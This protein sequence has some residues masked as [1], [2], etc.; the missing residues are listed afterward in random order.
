MM[1][2]SPSSSYIQRE[3]FEPS[4]RLPEYHETLPPN[5]DSTNLGERVEAA[6]IPS[7]LN[8]GRQ[9]ILRAIGAAF[10]VFPRLEGVPE[11]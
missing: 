3:L 4:V 7:A 2:Y 11:S 5:A 1:R 10:A 9:S 6:L 8:N